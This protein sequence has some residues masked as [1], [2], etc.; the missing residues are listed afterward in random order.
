MIRGVARKT[1]SCAITCKT[2]IR[3][4]N[5][6]ESRRVRVEPVRTNA[7]AEIVGEKV[8]GRAIGAVS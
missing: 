7:F 6:L 4:A 1:N 5:A 8:A 3:T 2:V